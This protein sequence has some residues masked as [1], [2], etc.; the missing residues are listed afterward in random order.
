MTEARWLYARAA[1]RDYVRYSLYADLPFG[2]PWPK[3]RL[4]RLSRVGVTEGDIYA[5]RPGADDPRFDEDGKPVP[6][7]L[8]SGPSTD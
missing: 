8:A 5:S 1:L 3:L 7:G 6:R 4:P 2:T